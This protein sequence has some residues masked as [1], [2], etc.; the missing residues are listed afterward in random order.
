MMSFYENVFCVAVPLSVRRM[1]KWRLWWILSIQITQRLIEIIKYMIVVQW[2]QMPSWICI[3]IILGHDDVIKWKHF[4]RYWPF[5]RGIHRFTVNSQHKG[6]WRGALIFSLSC[7]R[8]NGWVSNG[9]A[10]DLRRHRAHYDATVMRW[11]DAE[12]QANKMR[13][14]WLIV[15]LGAKWWLVEYCFNATVTDHE[16]T[17]DFKWMLFVL[18]RYEMSC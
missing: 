2:H 17:L 12:Y 8:I 18:W 9:E 6:Q 16:P 3:D 15:R 14:Y 4:P 10:G 5:V 13:K 7:T 1:C 11:T